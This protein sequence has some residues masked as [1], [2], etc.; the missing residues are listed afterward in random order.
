MLTKRQ[1]DLLVFLSNHVNERGLM[2]AY[3][4][5]ASAIGVASKSGIHRLV[6]AL[7]ERGYIRRIPNRARAIEI[8]RV[9]RS[10]GGEGASRYAMEIARSLSVEALEAILEEKR[11]AV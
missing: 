3:V 7:E 8:I 4:E 6:L 5:M 1:R 9:P 2:P 10:A 11:L